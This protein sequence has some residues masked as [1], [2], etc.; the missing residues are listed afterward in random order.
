MTRTM[1][2]LSPPKAAPLPELPW[3]RYWGLS[4]RGGEVLGPEQAGRRGTCRARS[5]KNLRSFT[6]PLEGAERMEEQPYTRLVLS[7]RG[8]M[9]A[10]RWVPS[11]CVLQGKACPYLL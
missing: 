9:A 5:A 11:W 10:G 8:R 4:R 2:S 7:K 6:I 1:V 3:V